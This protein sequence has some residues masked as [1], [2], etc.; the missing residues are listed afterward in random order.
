MEPSCQFYCLIRKMSAISLQ[1]QLPISIW[2]D[3]QVRTNFSNFE[4]HQVSSGNRI[5]RPLH[6]WNVF[7]FYLISLVEVFTGK[8]FERLLHTGTEEDELRDGTPVSFSSNEDD[9]ELRT[10]VI[11]P[12]LWSAD[13][14]TNDLSRSSSFDERDERCD[15][16]H[17]DIKGINNT[18]AK[19]LHESQLLHNNVDIGERRK[20]KTFPIRMTANQVCQEL[21]R[22]NVSPHLLI[23]PHIYGESLGAGAGVSQPFE[24]KV[25]PQVSMIKFERRMRYN[26]T[27]RSVS[28]S[29]FLLKNCT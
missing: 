6:S 4:M 21:S 9:Q 23:A 25:H 13:Y 2:N 20:R 14:F 16:D 26:R 18:E 11:G 24:V 19:L 12:L 29:K 8:I 27:R 7:F 5:W 22:P 28:S 1:V 10:S 17:L 3:E 15:G